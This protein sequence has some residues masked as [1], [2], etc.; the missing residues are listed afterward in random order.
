MGAAARSSRA[1]R[2][3]GVTLRASPFL[4]ASVLNRCL[5][6]LR[7]L[8]TAASVTAS[9]LSMMANPSRSSSSVMHSG[10]FVKK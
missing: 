7:Y 2:G 4:R 5:R 6:T 1:E 3:T 10:G 9:A 8:W